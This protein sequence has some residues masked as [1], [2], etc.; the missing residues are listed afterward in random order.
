[1]LCD[2]SNVCASHGTAVKMALRVCF[3]FIGPSIGCSMNSIIIRLSRTLWDVLFTLCVH[4][5]VGG[6]WE[7]H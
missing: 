3:V 7:L 4:Y 6:L 1:M 5:T 2:F